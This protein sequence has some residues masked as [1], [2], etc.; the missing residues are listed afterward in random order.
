MRRI[1]LVFAVIFLLLLSAVVFAE[2]EEDQSSLEEQMEKMGYAGYQLPAQQIQ[3]YPQITPEQPCNGCKM[4]DRCIPY[5]AKFTVLAQAGENQIVEVPVVCTYGGITPLKEVGA[6]CNYNY[7]CAS[8]MCVKNTCTTLW[9]L[10][11]NWF[12][13]VFS[14]LF[15]G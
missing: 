10:I 6:F 12:A 11:K 5:G 7:E 3:Q 15:P 13:K 1:V 2:N 14:F 4:E 8:N 9:L